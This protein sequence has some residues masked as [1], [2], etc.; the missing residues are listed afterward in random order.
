MI[1]RISLRY[2]LSTEAPFKALLDIK[3]DVDFTQRRDELVT[4]ACSV[5]GGTTYEDII[6]TDNHQKAINSA[7]VKVLAEM[8]NRVGGMTHGFLV[9]VKDFV[10][11]L[12][13]VKKEAEEE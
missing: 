8:A 1:A 9:G 11:S 12:Y 4:R 2:R 5:P 10:Q 7:K 6:E 3:E 13:K